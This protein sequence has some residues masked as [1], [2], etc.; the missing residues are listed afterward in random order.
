MASP[1]SVVVQFLVDAKKAAGDAA[2]FATSLGKVDTEAS[3]LDTSLGKV[4]AAIDDVGDKARST[5]TELDRI[6][7]DSVAVEAEL[8]ARRVRSAAQDMSDGVRAGATDIDTETG[9]IKQNMADTG[10]EAGAEFIGNIAEGI[11]SGTANITEVIQGTLGGVTNLAASLGGPLG[12]AFGVAA[13]GAGVLFSTMKADIERVKEKVEELTDALSD[14]GTTASEEAKTIIWDTWLANIQKFPGLLGN[15]TDALKIANIP[16]QVFEDA[17]KG[18]PAA[19]AKVRDGLAQV[20]DEI[21]DNVRKG[22]PLTE[23]QQH[24]LEISAD[25]RDVLAEQGIVIDET[26]DI[27]NDI[28]FL[29]GKNKK[30]AE[31]WAQN[32]MDVYNATHKTKLDYDAMKDKDVSL[33][34]DVNYRLPNGR[35]LSRTNGIMPMDAPTAEG[36][37]AP[38]TV[39]FYSQTLTAGPTTI[40]GL[41]RQLEGHN[42]RMGRPPGV[43]RA[44]SW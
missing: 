23:D 21:A 2:Q 28:E 40:R 20:G 37:A 42:V 22:K 1:G 32:Q 19:I 35:K 13:A 11:G 17:I 41:V 4:E 44:V 36:M 31:D 8:A 38:V 30:N 24:Y 6:D 39:N 3:G 34:V 33:N 7:F 16:A 43:P 9:H 12:V 25:V 15:V 29:S 18:D 10:K 27:Q 14:L 5:D 26:R